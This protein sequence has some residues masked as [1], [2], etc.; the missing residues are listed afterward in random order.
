MRATHRVAPTFSR[1]KFPNARG[2]LEEIPIP[3]IV[4]NVL[5]LPSVGIHGGDGGDGDDIVDVVA[6]LQHVHGRA[7]A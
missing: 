1:W 5:A 7:H 4:T 6:G 3:Q 2:S